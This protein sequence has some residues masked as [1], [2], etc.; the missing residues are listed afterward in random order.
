MGDDGSGSLF[1]FHALAVLQRSSGSRD[2]WQALDLGGA[3]VGTVELVDT[4]VPSTWGTCYELR[5][6]FG[7]RVRIVAFL[8]RS[9]M[10]ENVARV[11]GPDGDQ[12]VVTIGGLVR[13]SRLRRAFHEITLGG[14]VLGSMNAYMNR[15]EDA[16]GECVARLHVDRDSIRIER[17][18]GDLFE[19]FVSVAVASAIFVWTS[20]VAMTERG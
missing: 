12:E 4:P 10:G 1:P 6:A 3:C 2:V 20:Y 16:D 19:P 14:D 5:N 15:I 7:E 17:P 8:E 18:S 13:T 9:E 11:T